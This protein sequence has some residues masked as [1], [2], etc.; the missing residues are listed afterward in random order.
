MVGDDERCLIHA[1]DGWQTH[2]NGQNVLLVFW[3][4]A[5]RDVWGSSKAQVFNFGDFSVNAKGLQMAY[6]LQSKDEAMSC[7]NQ[8]PAWRCIISWSKPDVNLR[9]STAVPMK[10]CWLGTSVDSYS[11][12]WTNRPQALFFKRYMNSSHIIKLKKIYIHASFDRLKTEEP[13]RW[14]LNSLFKK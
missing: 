12:K 4:Y 14:S 13:F 8:R 5:D 11:W 2:A 3:T 10:N 7:R 6:R 9:V 1:N